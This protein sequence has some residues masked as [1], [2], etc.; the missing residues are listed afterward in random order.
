MNN[1]E[2]IWSEDTISFIS[3][4][5]S[6]GI[7]TI[8]GIILFYIYKF[9]YKRTCIKQI[10]D[11]NDKFFIINLCIYVTSTLIL[12]LIFVFIFRNILSFSIMLIVL[13]LYV[14]LLTGFYICHTCYMAKTEQY[15]EVF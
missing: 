11:K 15:N 4:I 12:S 13:V 14:L 1:N 9:A 7:A 6:V 5:F 8:I 10:P 3:V 2:T